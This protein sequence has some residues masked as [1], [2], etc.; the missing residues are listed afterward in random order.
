MMVAHQLLRGNGY[1][2]IVRSGEFINELIPMHPNQVSVDQASWPSLAL[3][4][5]WT[6]KNGRQF[7]V[8][9]RDM[10]HF[11]NLSTNGVVGR[12][13]LEDA[14]DTFGVAI[15]TQDHAATFWARSG[16]PTVVLTHPQNLS[17][18]AKTGLEAH[19]E[20]TYGGGKDARRVAVL[21]EGMTINTLSVTAEDA[22]FLETR[23]FQ[24]GEIAGLF[25]I[26]PHLIGDTEKSTSWGTGIEQQNIGL[27]VFTINPILT[28]MEARM[29]AD[30][31]SVP[32]KYG[33]KFFP[34]A[35][36][37][38]DVA[39]RGQWYRIMREIGAYS[40]NDVRRFEDESPVEG[41]DTYLQP[42][43]LAPLGWQPPAESSSK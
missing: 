43:N 13:V 12:S 17:E 42:L 18:K 16:L 33:V 41:G 27:V 19:F 14:R 22:Q 26:P 38:G 3:T 32:D 29:N 6:A 40:A 35:L 5:K 25:G 15:A 31:V 2:L 20:H 30:L 24:R 8:A 39:A 1:A 28:R 36:M 11:P 23:K 10:L 37:R 7:E 4:Y 9:Q 34:Q 21:E